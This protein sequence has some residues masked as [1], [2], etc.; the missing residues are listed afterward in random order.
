MEDGTTRVFVCQRN[1]WLF[2][3]DNVNTCTPEGGCTEVGV[4]P[5]IGRLDRADGSNP[6]EQC[7]YEMDPISPVSEEQEE[8][9]DDHE[10]VFRRNADPVVVPEND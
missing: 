10:V 5:V 2:S 8:I 9:L 6:P 4:I 3:V 1:Q 7:R